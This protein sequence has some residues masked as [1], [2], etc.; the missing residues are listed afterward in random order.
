MKKYHITMSIEIEDHENIYQKLPEVI[1]HNVENVT[2]KL[3]QIEETKQAP[4]TWP[5]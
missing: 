4:S 1:N 2:V 3:H 5:L